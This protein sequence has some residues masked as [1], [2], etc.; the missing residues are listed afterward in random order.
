MAG[1]RAALWIAG[2]FGALA[3]AGIAIA[4]A[5]PGTV[6]PAQHFGA[7]VNPAIFSLILA[8]GALGSLWRPE[9]QR[10]WA[11]PPILAVSAMLGASGLIW[12]AIEVKQ[13]STYLGTIRTVLADARGL[14]VPQA[15]EA[16]LGAHERRIFRT[17]A[18]SWA[19]PELSLVLAPGGTVSAIVARERPVPWKTWDPADPAQV[20]KSRFWDASAYRAALSGRTR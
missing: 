7:R 10:W 8:A 4:A 2:G 13:W 16:S 11:R 19:Y 1:R 17:M 9:R 3:L 12:H 14:V 20:P 5:A 18:W 15:I 6:S